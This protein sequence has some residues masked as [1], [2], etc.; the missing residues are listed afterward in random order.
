[1]AGGA[2]PPLST[3]VAKAGLPASIEVEEGEICVHSSVGRES[4]MAVGAFPPLSSVVAKADLSASVEG[5][6]G[7]LRVQSQV[8]LGS[9]SKVVAKPTNVGKLRYYPNVMQDG[10]VSPPFHDLPMEYWTVDGLSHL[11]SG[12][13]KPL[14]MDSQTTAMDRI[15]YAK[16]CI[17]FPK[18]IALPDSLSIKR[19]DENG[20]ILCDSIAVSYPWKPKSVGR[21]WVATRRVFK[22]GWFDDLD[23]VDRSQEGQVHVQGNQCLVAGS[24]DLRP[25]G[26]VEQLAS[27]GE[28][29]PSQQP[30]LCSSPT[31]SPAVGG[32]K[33][34]LVVEVGQGVSS[35]AT[36]PREQTP[37]IVGEILVSGA[38]GAREVK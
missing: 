6:E 32:L 14:C 16:I 15:G 22:T 33:T 21:K 5:E 34:G 4:S 25:G 7:S 9:W 26:P 10:I 36:P 8:G 17:E 2:F 30:L 13:G 29:T 37:F 23:R 35:C 31:Q 20:E 1:M 28:A 38:S 3:V 27:V 18:D 19:L 24:A 11:A 12:I